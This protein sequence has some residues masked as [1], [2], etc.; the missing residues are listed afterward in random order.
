MTIGADAIADARTVDEL[1]RAL[2][3]GARL[4]ARRRPP[5]CSDWWDDVRNGLAGSPDGRLTAIALAPTD[6]DGRLTVITA[7][8]APDELRVAAIRRAL[9]AAAEPDARWLVR[10]DGLRYLTVGRHQ[11]S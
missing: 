8:D 7:A 4:V 5:T 1:A 10:A 11:T 6:A 3:A 9:Q 2:G